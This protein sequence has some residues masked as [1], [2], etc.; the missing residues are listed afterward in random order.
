MSGNQNGNDG[1]SK[2]L[3]PPWFIRVFL[4]ILIKVG[5]EGLEKVIKF[6]VVVENFRTLFYWMVVGVIVLGMFL[7]KTFTTIDHNE[8]LKDV[9]GEGN[10]CG[11]FDFPPSTYF[12]PFFWVW[13][14]GF[15][16][17]YSG[18]SIFRI[19][20]AYEEKKIESQTGENWT[21]RFLI[22]AHIYFIFS[23]MLFTTSIAV[24]PDRE[25]P[26]TMIFHTVPYVNWKIGLF[27][28]QVAVVQFGVNVA[29]KDFKFPKWFV[30]LCWFHVVLQGI[31][32]VT[33]N[34][35]IANALLDMGPAPCKRESVV[36]RAG[37]G[38]TTVPPS[39]VA[40]LCGNGYW[41]S[42]R[43]DTMKTLQNIFTNLA[44]A[45]LNFV[46][47]L[48]QSQY[49]SWKGC[50]EKSSTHKVIISFSDN[51]DSVMTTQSIKQQAEK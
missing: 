40:G 38:H 48:I 23:V 46:F 51:K 32:M 34:I 49:L 25:D 30:A 29:W 2:S 47:P 17:A 13:T 7:T 12:L 26:A 10:V 16:I 42:V 8:I 21:R 37:T 33:S 14:M 39:N 43:D 4:D 31:V 5:N 9:F 6:E 44:S 1:T 45:L 20:I 41:W 36:L 24:Q 50:K 19:W 28:L 22:F 35:F 11:Y 15:A 27:L 18:V 3:R